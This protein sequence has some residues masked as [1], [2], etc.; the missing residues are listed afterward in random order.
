MSAATWNDATTRKILANDVVLVNICQNPDGRIAD[1]RRN[2]N[3]FDLNRDW[4]TQSQS[5]VR[6]VARQIVKWHPIM[7]L[8][9]HGY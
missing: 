1:A 5:E 6:A 2:A 3:G 8:D 9:L 4:I 7:F